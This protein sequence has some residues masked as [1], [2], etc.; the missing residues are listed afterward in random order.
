MRK[1]LFN[2]IF[3]SLMILCVLLNCYVDCYASGDSFELENLSQSN[4]TEYF[5]NL[6]LERIDDP[7]FNENFSCFGVSENGN[8]AL[9]YKRSR[10]CYVLIYD[11]F[12]TFI[13]GFKFLDD[14]SFC[15]ELF[16]TCFAIYTFRGNLAYNVTYSGECVS[17]KSIADTTENNKYWQML[18]KGRRTVGEYEYVAESGWL[19]GG[20]F[21]GG[22]YSKLIKIAPSGEEMLLYDASVMGHFRTVIPT[23]IALT[24]MTVVVPIIC[25]FIVRRAKK[26]KNK[27]KSNPESST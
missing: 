26:Q 25:I 27:D 15:I 10:E 17:V 8:Y 12:G 1:I 22:T 14:G 16:D 13:A 24:T 18:Q 2:I 4:A 9:S 11:M 3:S 20:I 21:S 23:V 5:E 19:N 6:K 7:N